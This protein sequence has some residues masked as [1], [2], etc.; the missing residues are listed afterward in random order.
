[1]HNKNSVIYKNKKNGISFSL[2]NTFSKKDFWLVLIAIE[3]V[4]LFT[5]ETF[6]KFVVEIV[7]LILNRPFYYFCNNRI[8]AFCGGIL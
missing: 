1:M 3:L 5:N 7:K 2:K 6:L 4:K 8:F